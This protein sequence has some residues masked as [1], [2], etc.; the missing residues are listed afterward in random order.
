MM[1]GKLRTM[2]EVLTTF[3]KSAVALGSAG[4][5][6]PEGLTQAMSETVRDIRDLA[7]QIKNEPEKKDSRDPEEF[8]GV[9][10]HKLSSK[11]DMRGER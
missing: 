9:G 1:E 5:A 10:V 6:V 8:D 7:T 4:V 11:K 3:T 2:Q